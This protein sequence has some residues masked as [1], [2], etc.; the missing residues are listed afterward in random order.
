MILPMSSVEHLS[1]HM[2]CVWCVCVRIMY[3]VHTVRIFYWSHVNLKRPSAGYALLALGLWSL[4]QRVNSSS[5]SHFIDFS[6]FFALSPFETHFSSCVK[7]V[8]NI[9]VYSM[10]FFL[11]ATYPVCSNLIFVVTRKNR[12]EKKKEVVNL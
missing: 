4:F 11:R 7:C 3:T 12:K 2:W 1:A 5:I 6:D 10:H 9:G 8:L